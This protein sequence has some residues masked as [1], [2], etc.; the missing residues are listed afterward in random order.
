MKTTRRATLAAG[1][2]ACLLPALPALAAAPPRG[3]QVA[4]WYRFRLGAFECTVISDGAITLAPPFPTFGAGVATEAEVTAALRRAFLPEDRLPT[5]INCLVVNTGS[6]LILLDAGVGAQPVFGPG[7]GRLVESLVAAGIQPAEVDLVA[8]THAHPDHAWGIADA[9]GNSVFPNARYAM[10]STDFDTWTNEA[11]L[12]QAEPIRGFV[13]GTRAVLLPRRDRFTMLAV[14]AQVAP[15]IRAVP[16]PGHT[17]GHVAF[18]LESEG[19]RLLVLGD[20]ANHHVL[21][22]SR[23]D[24]PFGFDSDPAQAAATRRRTLDMAATDRLQ[25]LGYH[26]PWPGLGHVETSGQGF[27]FVPTPWQWG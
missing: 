24:W 27:A 11:L 2:G 23:P 12:S 9:A 21:A 1:F 16:T 22:L 8:F 4:G 19:R 10:S 18:H 25:V 26:F 15:G 6:Q 7:T 14:N 20:I 5:A 17:P 3:G 13:Q